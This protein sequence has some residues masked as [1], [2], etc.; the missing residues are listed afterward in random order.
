LFTFLEAYKRYG[1]AIADRHLVAITGC[2][3]LARLSGASPVEYL[4]DIDV[5]RVRAVAAEMLVNPEQSLDRYI[6]GK[7]DSV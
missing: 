7:G 6:A 5:P 2:L 3:L 1:P 4:A